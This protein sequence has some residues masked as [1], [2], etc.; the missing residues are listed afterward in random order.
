[1]Y[2]D[3]NAGAC[4]YFC[5]STWFADNR[6]QTCVQTCPVEWELFGS[7]ATYQCVSLCENYKFAD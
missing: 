3:S 7:F 2:G 5:T 6:T 4:V 1:M